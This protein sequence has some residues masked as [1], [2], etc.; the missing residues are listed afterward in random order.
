MMG[1]QKHCSLD[2]FPGDWGYPVVGSAFDLVKNPLAFSRERVA[3]FGEISRLRLGPERGLMVVGADAFR[4]IL[5]DSQF[6]FSAREGY[7]NQLGRFYEGGLL[8]RDGADH[9]GQ[10]RLMQQVFKFTTMREYVPRIEQMVIRQIE[11]WPKQQYFAF[12][13]AIKSALLEIGSDIFLGIET[14]GE[15]SARVHQSFLDIAAG[16]GS[17]FPWNLPGTNI[18]RG[19]NGRNRLHAFIR[20]S[21]P[22]RRQGAGM[23]MFS[24]LAQAQT[25]EDNRYSDLEIC[26][27]VAFLLFAAHDTTT[28]LLSHLMMY[29]GK[30]PEWQAQLRLEM[31]A[32]NSSTLSWDDQDR[33]PTL[34][35]VL[36]EVLRLHPPVPLMVRKTSGEVELGGRSIPQGTMLYLPSSFNQRDRRYWTNPDAFD[37]GRFTCHRAEDKQHPFIFHPFGGGAHKCIGMHFAYLLSRVFLFHLLQRYEISLPSQHQPKLA[38]I[39]IPYPVDG[40]PVRL[41]PI[42]RTA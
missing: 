34:K 11:E 42:E 3:R 18:R 13:P 5:T 38:W 7:S 37:P 1:T 26:Q 31:Q 35:T 32:L 33:M 8:L 30:H 22:Q 16:L 28:S 19:I 25:E 14:L 27:H 29:L 10:R 36:D 39:P 41:G 24:L 17:I 15:D 23:D 9:K 40:P 20:E 21:I 2:R 12:Y 6:Q 4:T